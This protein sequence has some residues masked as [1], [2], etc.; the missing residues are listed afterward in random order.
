MGQLVVDNIWKRFP[1]SNATE[2]YW[3]TQDELDAFNH[4][5][6]LWLG[7]PATM[8]EEYGVKAPSYNAISNIKHKRA[9]EDLLKAM[10]GR[11]EVLPT[12]VNHFRTLGELSRIFYSLR[13][14]LLKEQSMQEKS[15]VLE[16]TTVDV[17]NCVDSFRNMLLMG[18]Y[19]TT[20]EEFVKSQKDHLPLPVNNTILQSNNTR[21]WILVDISK[22]RVHEVPCMDAESDILFW[23]RK[24]NLH[25]SSKY[26]GNLSD[27]IDALGTVL[28]PTEWLCEQKLAH[29]KG[30]ENLC[31]AFPSP[32]SRMHAST[33]NVI[34]KN[35][36]Y[37]A[38]KDN[39]EM[40]YLPCP[41]F[42]WTITADKHL[43]VGYLRYLSKVF[44]VQEE[45]AM[46]PQH[47][48]DTNRTTS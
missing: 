15:N 6:D 28:L 33:E 29:M 46:S 10:R 19:G 40:K 30:G 45:S 43:I 24:S 31:D 16:Y 37:F 23:K 2:E 1:Q 20:L 38:G 13:M 41:T 12:E 44:S 27:R 18:V 21:V 14:E 7:F 8:L 3:L 42:C 26:L 32:I 11:L 39:S 47:W 5:L 34:K 4:L 35:W 9:V 48:M 25:Y 22:M 17:R 36:V